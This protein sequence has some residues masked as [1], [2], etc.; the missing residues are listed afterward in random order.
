MIND[1]QEKGSSSKKN[2]DDQPK[3]NGATAGLTDA[4]IEVLRGKFPILGVDFLRANRLS[5]SV[6][7]NQLTDD[8]TGDTFRLIEQPSGHTASVML[9]ANVPEWNK[10][11]RP[12]VAPVAVPQIIITL[13]AADRTPKVQ[14]CRL[15]AIPE[16]D[17]ARQ[18]T[19]NA[20]LQ[21]RPGQ[22]SS[23]KTQIPS[24]QD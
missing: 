16:E 6:A 18:D 22:T 8:S 24:H 13:P 17:H 1:D 9:P 2:D 11:A 20:D 7:T 21:T 4:D 5:V 12:P 3:H 14:K 23:Q 15:P 10:T 19:H